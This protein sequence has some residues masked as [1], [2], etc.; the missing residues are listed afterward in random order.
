MF[1]LNRRFGFTLIELLVVIAIIAVLA[2]I[3]FPIFARARQ[4]ARRTECAS[5]LHQIGRALSAY[6]SDFNGGFPK[7]DSQVVPLNPWP[8]RLSNYAPD[9]AA[10]RC[11]D[12]DDPAADPFTRKWQW[13]NEPYRYSYGINMRVAAD[14]TSSPFGLVGCGIRDRAPVDWSRFLLVMEAHWCWFLEADEDAGSV[15]LYGV[16]QLEWRHPR[17]SPRLALNG[18]M[19]TLLGDMHVKYLKKGTTAQIVKAGYIFKIFR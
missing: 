11:P 2:A 14:S 13:K 1:R 18:G 10:F 12:D 3:L 16:N 5:N 15:D 19:N 4:A 7:T 17:P 8:E 6:A 9:M